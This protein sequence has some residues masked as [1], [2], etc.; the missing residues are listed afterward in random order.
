MTAREAPRGADTRH[1]MPAV[2]YGDA[3]E[4]SSLDRRAAGVTAR[5]PWQR[6]CGTGGEAALGVVAGALS[7]VVPAVPDCMLGGN[8]AGPLPGD[9][10]FR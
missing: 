5:R 3:D 6:Q 2:E 10:P 1:T 9:G 8:G 4:G 7:L